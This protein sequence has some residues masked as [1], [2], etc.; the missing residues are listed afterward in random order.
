MRSSMRPIAAL[1]LLAGTASVFAADW[2]T[3]ASDKKRTIELDRASVLQSDPGTK[4]AWGRIVLSESEAEAAGYTTVKALNRYDCRNQTF[5]TIKR[6]YLDADSAVLKDE[7]V[8]VEKDVAVAQGSVD[9][10]LWRDVCKPGGGP[11]DISQL[12]RTASKAAQSA[13]AKSR[14]AQPRSQRDPA[15]APQDPAQASQTQPRPQ[16]AQPRS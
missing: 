5:A 6:V 15:Q 14:R 12:A 3:V 16:R 11:A 4:V 13:Q 10:K 9:E 1:L 7:K 2:Q 8:K